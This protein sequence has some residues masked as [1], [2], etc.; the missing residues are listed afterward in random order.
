MNRQH[1]HD[2]NNTPAYLKIQGYTWSENTPSK[3]RANRAAR[4]IGDSCDC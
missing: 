3:Q 4:T 2:V 1:N